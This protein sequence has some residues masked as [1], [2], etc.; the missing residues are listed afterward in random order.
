MVGCHP[1]RG[2]VVLGGWVEVGLCDF[3]REIALHW[4][5]WIVLNNGGTYCQTTDEYCNSIELVMNSFAFW[6]LPPDCSAARR[7]TE[8]AFYK[9]FATNASVFILAPFITLRLP[10]FHPVTRSFHKWTTR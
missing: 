9:I 1:S 6:Y 5:R 7:Q 4:V 3:V 8:C 10:K 2:V